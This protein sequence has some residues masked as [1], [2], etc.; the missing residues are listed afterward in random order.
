[1]EQNQYLPHEWDDDGC[2]VHCG[3]D[4]AE[5][6]HWVHNTYEGRA[7]DANKQKLPVCRDWQTGS[8]RRKK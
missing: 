8:P 4:G 7:A 5:H 3:F 2:C 6:W 1:M